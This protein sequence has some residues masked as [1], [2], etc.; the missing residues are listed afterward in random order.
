MNFSGI[1]IIICIY[2]GEYRIA[3][4]LKALISQHIPENINVEIL[5]VDNGSTDKT[6]QVVREFWLTQQTNITLRIISEPKQGKA[7]ALITGYNEAMYELMLLCD[8]DNWLQPEYIKTVFEIYNEHPD[9]GLL[10]GYGKAFFE[11][12]EKPKWFGKWER[13]Y[14]CGKH[15]KKNG[16]LDDMD[17]RIWGAGSVMRKTLWAF[18]WSNGFT[19]Y[20]SADE[21]KAMTEDAELSMA[22]TFTGHRLYFD[23]SLWFIHDLHGGRIT[24]EN[25][26]AQQSLNGANSAILYMYRLAY[27]HVSDAH[28]P[29]NWLFIRKILG[30]TWRI[31][32]SFL[33]WDNYPERI[34]LYSIIRELLTNQK[35]YK[36]LSLESFVWIAKV[37]ETFPL[38]SWNA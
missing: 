28:P 9:I 8:D 30:L 14:V 21:G 38:K 20:N 2:N 32:K 17:F 37:K 3:P 18:L 35:K 23:D 1:S 33:K 25:L 6:I 36:K 4:T 22:I 29:V 26:I 19:F 24:W 12:D 13:C 10:G 34:F 27:D 7:N 15:H 31:F 5:L 16:F 11:P